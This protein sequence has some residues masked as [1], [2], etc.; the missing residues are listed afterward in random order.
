M[1]GMG[2]CPSQW[3]V[4]LHKDIGDGVTVAAV[5]VVADV[6]AIDVE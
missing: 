3:T 4:Q 1:A 5:D 6:A 2:Q